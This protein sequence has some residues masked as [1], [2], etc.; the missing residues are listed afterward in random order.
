MHVLLK[1]VSAASALLLLV[2]CVQVGGSRG[3][4]EAGRLAGL[5]RDT[6]PTDAANKVAGL[7]ASNR[8]AVTVHTSSRVEC[9]KIA[10][11]PAALPAP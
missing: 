10:P 6:S 5:F 4:P 2:A 11:N 9:A 8:I 3:D 7:C 1:T